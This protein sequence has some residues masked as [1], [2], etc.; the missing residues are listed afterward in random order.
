MGGI[1]HSSQWNTVREQE[2]NL[3]H[4]RNL[5]F[6]QCSQSLISV[7]PNFINRAKN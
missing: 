6:F 1:G 5:W 7:D 3:R 2:K 4:L